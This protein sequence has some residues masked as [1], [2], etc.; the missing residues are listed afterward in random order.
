MRDLL[1]ILVSPVVWLAA[2]SAVYGL[3]GILCEI[4]PGAAFAGA[5]WRRL[6]L[7]IAFALA[8]LVQVGLLMMLHSDRFGAAPGF[9]QVV[10]RASGWVGLVAVVWTLFPV[11][12]TSTCG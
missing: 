8:I 9:S 10:S 3:H 2:L 1:R 4:D 5:S 6:S 11:L 12:T 7:A